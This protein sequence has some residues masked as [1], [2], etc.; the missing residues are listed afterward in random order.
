MSELEITPSPA[1]D[2]NRRW[3]RA[4]DRAAWSVAEPEVR[5]LA[6]GLLPERGV[7][8]VL[9]VGAGVG[10]HALMFARAGFA[11]TACD[12][13]AA[14][15]A[16]CRAAADDEGLPLRLDVA[17]MTALP[18][19]AAAFDHVLAFNVLD[20]GELD[21]VRR[22]VVEIRRVLTPPGLVHA[23]LPSARD[24]GRGAGGTTVAAGADG[25]PRLHG[26]ARAVLA[27]FDGFEPLRLEDR[28][29]AGGAWY[30]H[31]LAERT[32]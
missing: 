25:R 20:Q 13:A 6:A 17:S 24:L 8:R 26:D 14:G 7:R 32:A 27:L 10:R 1:A 12:V 4:R 19:P 15:L 22:A 2:W 11:V 16:V 21:E 23:T 5:A 28:R 9:D 30:W 18:Y 29:H 3:R 31:L